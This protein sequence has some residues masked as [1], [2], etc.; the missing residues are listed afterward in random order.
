MNASGV[1]DGDKPRSN[2]FLP[3]Y[4]HFIG[5][6]WLGGESKKTIAITNPATGELLAHIQA[7]N[8]VDVGRAVEAA[9]RAFKSWSRSHP[10]A[11]QAVLREMARR[12]RARLRDFAMMETLDNGKPIRDSVG[13][14]MPGTAAVYDYFADLPLHIHG[15]TMDFPDAIALTHREPLGVC[16]AIVPW[17]IP[18]YCTS[19][20]VAP[21]LAAGNTVVLKPAESVCLAI[22]EF[23]RECADI[24]P[25][26]VVNI[27]TGYGQEAGEPLV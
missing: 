19:L 18:M 13:F 12:L 6:E 25:P 23:F 14:D 16:A 1:K 26:G 22:L 21:A 8:A 5:G 9:D 27:V 17:N 11:R 15:E 10:M 7:G 20:K 3:T 24:I 4:G 2:P